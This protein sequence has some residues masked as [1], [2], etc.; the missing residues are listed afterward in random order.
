MMS[1]MR[2]GTI[3]LA[4]VVFALCTRSQAKD[5]NVF[6]FGAKG[7][8][9]TLD[10]APIQRAIDAAADNGGR[11]VIP[12]GQKFLVATLELKSG[13]D[14]H[15]AG[16]LLISTNRNDYAGDGVI[17]ASNAPNINITGSG[18]INGRSLSYM[19]G[20][21][22]AGEWWLFKEWRPKIFMLVGCTNLS[23]RNIAFGDAPYWG[24]HLLGCKQVD[25]RNVTVKNRLDVPNC[26]GIDLDHCCDVK[27][28]G[29]R[30]TSGDDAIVV[31]A[32]RQSIDYG[33]SANIVVTDCVLT[34]QDSGLKIGTETTADVHDVLFEHCKILSGSRGLTIQLR[35]EGNVYNINFRHIQFTSRYYA[36]P[37]WGRGEAISL[38]AIPR[39][40]S[41]KLGSMHG[42]HI[43]DVS[44][45]AEN[46]IRI[47][48]SAGSRPHDIVLENV[49]LRF[50]RWTSYHG[51]VFD[52]RPTKAMADVEPHGTDGIF[53][54][55]ADQIHLRHCSVSW[56]RNCPDYFSHALETSDVAG[57]QL[58]DFSGAAAHPARDEAI[59]IQ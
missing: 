52:N 26:D 21:D 24:L 54:S 8:G 35:D 43:E 49:A 47:C 6:D 32:T 28:S 2:T 25:I 10:T 12:R 19:T 31:K 23:V 42:I 59:S 13:I 51:G 34:T 15:L 56:G 11:V 3:I 27:I 16:E 44:G 46:S 29:C 14:F 40:A 17:T 18:K 5:F 45:H 7:D 33:S 57:L 1:V 30:I 39:T 22:R 50:N 38:T 36:D 37:W 41:T 58:T 9:V 53:I 55:H 4:A 48:G 20:Y